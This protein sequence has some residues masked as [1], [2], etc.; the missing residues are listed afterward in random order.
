M[1]LIRNH[2]TQIASILFMVFSITLFPSCTYKYHSFGYEK[3]VIQTLES[4]DRISVLMKDNQT[5]KL[6]IVEVDQFAL[7]GTDKQ[8]RIVELPLSEITVVQKL[9]A[10][11]KNIILIGGALAVATVLVIVFINTFEGPCIGGSC[12]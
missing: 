2:N 10:D 5:Y 8:N 1:K 12:D 7:R 9:K 4:G 6:Q 11:S 3:D